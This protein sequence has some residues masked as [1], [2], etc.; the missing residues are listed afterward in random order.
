MGEKMLLDVGLRHAKPGIKDRRLN[1]GGGLYLLIK[2]TGAKW[3]RLDYSIGGK[4]KTLSLGVYPET[5]LADAR[6]KADKARN[7]VANGID[8]SDIRKEVKA[9]QLVATENERRL[10]SGLTII[11][12]FAHIAEEL[13]QRK[14]EG[15]ADKNNR[16]KRMLERNIL[17]WFGLG[18][19]L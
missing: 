9:A 6:G 3:W 14:V 17:P 10:D 16:S 7:Q 11:D 12:S 15:W 13:G 18:Q 5:S 1:D 19:S 4:R 8:P 2:P